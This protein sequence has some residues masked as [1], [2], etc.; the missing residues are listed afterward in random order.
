MSNTVVTSSKGSLNLRDVVRS[1]GVAFA[2]AVISVIY[3]TLLPDD[4]SFS[5]I[6]WMQVLKQGVTA[7]LGYLAINVFQKPKI[8][9]IDPDEDLMEAAKQGKAEITIK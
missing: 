2:T 4:A 8:V 6:D 3:A 7:S 1:V 5:D 9:V